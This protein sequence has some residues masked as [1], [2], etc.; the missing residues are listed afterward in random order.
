[1]I[2][3]SFFLQQT[4]KE[5]QETAPAYLRFRTTDAARTQP[6][7][8]SPAVSCPLSQKLRPCRR[9]G[10][11]LLTTCTGW[12][13]AC[14]APPLRVQANTGR[15]AEPVDTLPVARSCSAPASRAA[16][17]LQPSLPI[18]R[19]TSAGARA[20]GPADRSAQ[21]RSAEKQ[22]PTTGYQFSTVQKRSCRKQV[23]LY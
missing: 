15:R 5:N 11:R 20:A 7:S 18:V 1:M 17:P 21:G 8:C 9:A 10:S 12:A 3:C 14:T 22:V 13:C 23:D 16:P 19:R 2:P 4:L 6:K